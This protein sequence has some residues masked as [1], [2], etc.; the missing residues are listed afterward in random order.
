MEGERREGE[1][2]KKGIWPTPKCWRGVLYA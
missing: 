2:V 1:E